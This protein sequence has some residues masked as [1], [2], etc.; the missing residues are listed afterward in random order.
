MTQV[1]RFVIWIC[2]H[3]TKTQ[4]EL[5]I[6]ELTDVLANR[7]PEVKPRDDFQEKHPHWRKY[8]VDPTPPRST[9][10]TPTSPKLNWKQLLVDSKK[11]TGKEVSP[12]VI[13]NPKNAIPNHIHCHWCSAPQEYLYY[14]NGKQHSQVRCKLCKHVSPVSQRY[15]KPAKYWCPHC[16]HP[17][18]LWKQQPDRSLYKCDWDGCSYFLSNKRKLNKLERLLLPTKSSQ[19]KLHYSYAE[20]HFTEEQLIP[21]SPEKKDTDKLYSIRNT[22]NTLC[23]V[24]TFHISLGLSA[25]KTA[26]VL[27]HV[28]AIPASYQTVLNYTQIAAYHCHKFNLAYKGDADP[29]QVGD[30]VCIK[31]S[32][33]KGYAFF[34]LSPSRRKITSYHCASNREVLPATI[35][36]KEAIRTVP[37]KTNTITAITDGN[38]SYIAAVDFLNRTE[39]A[40]LTHKK[41]I[42]L[43]NLD[44]ESEEYRPFK[45]MIERLS[46]SFRFHTNAACGFK[47]PNGAIALTTLFTTHYNFLRPHAFLNYE[48]PCPLPQLQGI[49]TLQGKWAKI[50]RIATT[51]A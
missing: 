43:Q 10:P 15:R 47:E 45:Q 46:R 48:V 34:F 39:N 26:F 12:V 51:I 28:F 16:G 31:V 23:L 7:N 40:G 3:F 33:K 8:S 2:R 18:Y 30:E 11:K 35:A 22:L 4:I 17:L 13:R 21:S 32:G 9:P 42:G 5:I 29:L 27:R 20:Y 14:N 49:A 41:V 37:D 24:L 6:K 38:P 1:S 44:T 50:L 25:R 19:F 36:L